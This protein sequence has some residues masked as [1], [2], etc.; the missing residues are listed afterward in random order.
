MA[1]GDKISATEQQQWIEHMLSKDN[2]HSITASQIDALSLGG[3]T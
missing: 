2:P 3:D 1:I